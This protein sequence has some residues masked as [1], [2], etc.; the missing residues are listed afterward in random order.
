VSTI[1]WTDERGQTLFLGS[2]SS[3]NQLQEDAKKGAEKLRKHM[4]DIAF[5][6]LSNGGKPQSESTDEHQFKPAPAIQPT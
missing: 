4:D 3:W 5:R 2:L 1:H 6:T